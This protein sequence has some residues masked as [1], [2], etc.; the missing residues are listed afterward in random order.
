MKREKIISR[1]N[2]NFRQQK[3]GS[4]LGNITIFDLKCK[5]LVVFVV[6]ITAASINNFYSMSMIFLS[7][8][9]LA[10]LTK[11]SRSK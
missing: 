7:T 4:L 3:D 6:L 10:Y 1:L 2:C 8:F 5:Y 11:G 9:T